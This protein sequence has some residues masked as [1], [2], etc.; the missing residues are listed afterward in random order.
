MAACLL[1]QVRIVLAFISLP[2]AQQFSRRRS[3]PM[4]GLP[5]CP[6]GNVGCARNPSGTACTRIFGPRRCRVNSESPET[7]HSGGK[8]DP[9]LHYPWCRS[10]RY[11]RTRLP[12]LILPPN[13]LRGRLA[14]GLIPGSPGQSER[15]NSSSKLPGQFT[16]QPVNS[17]WPH[18]FSCPSRPR[19]AA[20]PPTQATRPARRYWASSRGVLC[21]TGR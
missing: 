15:S 10:H 11:R 6:S 17:S 13:G 9:R 5:I 20:C 16:G 4:N 19:P 7:P 8:H 1:I 3:V 14:V 12:R 2:H 21:N 18:S